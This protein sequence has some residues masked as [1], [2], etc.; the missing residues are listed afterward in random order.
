MLT[1]S[2]KVIIPGRPLMLF[3]LLYKY[4]FP[5]LRIGPDIGAVR[6]IRDTIGKQPGS[7]V[8]RISVIGRITDSKRPLSRHQSRRPFLYGA[9]GKKYPAECHPLIRPDFG[10]RQLNGK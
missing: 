2:E 3:H 6:S 9:V 1:E 4:T 8:N 5:Q 7:T 10:D